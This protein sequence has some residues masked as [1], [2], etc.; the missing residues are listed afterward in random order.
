MAARAGTIKAG[1][2]PPY[3]SAL[4]TEVAH[5]DDSVPETAISGEESMPVCRIVYLSEA[6]GAAGSSLLSIAE[7]LGV[8]DRNNRRDNLTGM[9]LS[10]GGRF[11]QV[12]EG[13]RGD[14][15]RLLDRLRHDPRHRNIKV[16]SDEA[17]ADRRFSGW[18]MGQAQVTPGLASLLDGVDLQN[19]TEERATALA[20]A[21]F[22]LAPAQA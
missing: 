9:L 13:S 21:A 10:H 3:R 6:V 14:I 5:G 20:T 2:P 22:D 8:S 17:A 16:I 11:M 4:L 18:A 12:L 7:I 15:D 1:S 19:L